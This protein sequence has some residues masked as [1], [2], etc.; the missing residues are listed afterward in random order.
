MTGLNQVTSNSD[1]ENK[2]ASGKPLCEDDPLCWRCGE[3]DS[4]HYWYGGLAC[5]ASAFPHE[6]SI[7]PSFRPSQTFQPDPPSFD[8]EELVRREQFL[9]DTRDWS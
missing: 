8:D 2:E 6:D 4:Q 3:P 5:C 9:R 7:D 1:F